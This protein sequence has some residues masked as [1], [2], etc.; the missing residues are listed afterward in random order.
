MAKGFSQ[1]KITIPLVFQYNAR[2]MLNEI[3]NP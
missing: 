3:M 2:F 1:L